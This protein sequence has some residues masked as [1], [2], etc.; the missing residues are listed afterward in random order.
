MEQ[1]IVQFSL[2]IYNR[3]VL[4]PKTDNKLRPSKGILQK[5]SGSPF[6]KGSGSLLDFSDASFHFPIR[7]H[8][9]PDG[10]L[11]RALCQETCLQH[12]Q[13][14]F[15]PLPR[16]GLGSKFAQVG[17]DPSANVQ[18]CKI[19][20]RPLLR[21]GPAHA[22]EMANF[23]TLNTDSNGT[24]DL[25]KQ[26]MSLIGLLIATEKQVESGHIHLRPLQ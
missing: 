22:R 7:I 4:V 25:L 19:L 13:T 3:L 10:W 12:S 6:S 21:P 1:V 8:Q 18:L 17:T 16:S 24:R 20:F 26:F 14:H 15:G 9:Y 5:P 23:H 11:L 2:A